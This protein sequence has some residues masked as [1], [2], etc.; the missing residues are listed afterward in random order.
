MICTNSPTLRR[1]AARSSGS[2]MAISAPS[3]NVMSIS[4]A[5]CSMRSTV[6][7]PMPR[8]GVLMTRL[9]AMSSAGLTT[10]VR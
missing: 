4:R 3:M 8:R 9:A 6:D 2:A 1:V 7:L 10:S 5:N